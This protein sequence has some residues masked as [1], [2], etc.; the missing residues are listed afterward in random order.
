MFDSALFKQV[1]RLTFL[2]STAFVAVVCGGALFLLEAHPDSERLGAGV[3]LGLV[4]LGVFWVR[5]LESRLADAGL[6]R[7]CFWPY[8][9]AVLAACGGAHVR[10]MLDGLETLAFFVAVQI[11]TVLFP[12][13]PMSDGPM[14]KAGA[15]GEAYPEYNRPVGRFQFLLRVLLIAALFDA[16]LQLARGAGPGLALW[17]M[18]IGIVLF[19]LVWIY[20]VEGKVM[21]AG[22]PRWIS[23]PYCLIL[24]GAI[25]L[26]HL[27]KL[28]NLDVA[29]ALFVV[30]QFPTV[31]FRSRTVSVGQTSM[32]AGEGDASKLP[33][34]QKNKPAASLDS[35]EFAVYTLLIA[36]L[37]YVLH[38]LRGD[39]GFGVLAWGLDSVLDGGAFFL[40]I[41]WTICVRRRL[42]DAGL[43]SW[44]L[45]FC[46][47]VFSVSLLPFAF[48]V[49]NFP[50][51]LLVFAALQIPAVLVRRGSI[52]EKF[53]PAGAE[54]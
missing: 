13:K 48:R 43:L 33:S 26:P 17:E 7:W 18:R 16:L 14:L 37:W 23:I 8:F 20:S 15:P 38:L 30:L 35:I 45:D 25:V 27:L 3:R 47:I 54:S 6:P 24:S 9:L 31:F 29:L 46:L 28:I 2:L 36:G 49:I 40:G 52:S 21:D 50:Q 42:R 53:F 34:R 51:A 39:A 32:D 44:A 1:G 11:P 4:L 41:L 5:S 22:L 19:A 12:S 10:G